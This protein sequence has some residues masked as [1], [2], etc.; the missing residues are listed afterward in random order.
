MGTNTV[1]FSYAYDYKFSR[2]WSAT[3]GI[4]ATYCY[5][6]LDYNKL[7]FGDQIGRGSSTSLQPVIPEKVSFVDFSAGLLVFS[8]K[9]WFG[10][11][12]NHLN[13][14]NQAF[15]ESNANLPRKGSIHGGINIPLEKGGDG[16]VSQKPY[17][18]V[19]SQYRFQQEFDQVDI[20]LYYK[21]P[22]YFIGMWYRGIP[23]FK[24]YKPGYSNHDAIAFLIG[25][26]YK[27]LNIGYSYDITISKLTQVSGG[28]HEISLNYQFINP[29]KPKKH[30]TKIV[31]CPKF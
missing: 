22:Y 9:K 23:L 8:S 21:K 3:G 17:I 4:R 27:Q 30:R 24:A 31:P 13:K 29:K 6:T 25:G 26:S 15:L 14:P 16:R 11:S 18:T 20:G 2:Y 5:R 7:I 12:I 19:A 10:I 28:S 1:G